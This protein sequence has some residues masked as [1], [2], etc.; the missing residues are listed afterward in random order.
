MD[1]PDRV[2]ECRD[3]RVLDAFVFVFNVGV[4]AVVLDRRLERYMRRRERTIDEERLVFVVF[5]LYNDAVTIENA[6][7]KSANRGVLV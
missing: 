5:D 2:I 1:I 6:L 4:L 3:H 7:F